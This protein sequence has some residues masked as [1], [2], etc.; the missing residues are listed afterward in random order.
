MD[1]DECNFENLNALARGKSLR[2]EAREGSR[3]E[4]IVARFRQ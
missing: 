3:R 2:R 1:T 4:V